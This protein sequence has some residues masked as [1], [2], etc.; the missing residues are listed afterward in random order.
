MI[1]IKILKLNKK[2]KIKKKSKEKI[3]KIE[4]TFI[5]L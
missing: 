1:K 3:F 4:K 2:I 5:N